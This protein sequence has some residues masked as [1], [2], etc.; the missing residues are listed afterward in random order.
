M[1]LDCEARRTMA[2][3]AFY[4]LQ[5]GET[6]SQLAKGAAEAVGLKEKTG[7]AESQAQ[8]DD[9]PAEPAKRASKTKHPGD[10]G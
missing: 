3:N 2:R 1:C 10:A 8:T 9:T 4:R 6:I 5:V 7:V